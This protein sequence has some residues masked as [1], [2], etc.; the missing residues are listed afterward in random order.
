MALFGDTD[1]DFGALRERIE[2]VTLASDPA[3]REIFVRETAF[4][5][6]GS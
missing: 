3:F 6:R 1:A 4:P 2:H 5:K